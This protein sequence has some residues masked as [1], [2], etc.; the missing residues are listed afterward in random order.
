MAGHPERRKASEET[1]S[2]AEGETFVLGKLPRKTVIT[3]TTGAG[4]G[5]LQ[6]RD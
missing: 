1:P 4:K 3:D 6:P 2:Q 5:T